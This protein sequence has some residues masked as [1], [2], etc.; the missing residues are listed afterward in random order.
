MK[1]NNLAT[2]LTQWS[3][4]MSQRRRRKLRPERRIR[5]HKHEKFRN[6]APSNSYRANFTLK[7]GYKTAGYKNNSHTR[8]IFPRTESCSSLNLSHIT[9]WEW[10]PL[11]F[12][13]QSGLLLALRYTQPLQ[14]I[15]SH[16][17]TAIFLLNKKGVLYP[18]S[19]VLWTDV[20]IK[21]NTNKGISCQT[22]EIK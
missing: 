20:E 7:T 11:L 16:L 8:Q 17:V 1:N 5:H 13:L 22:I 2:H 10:I 6:L 18:V 12:F 9:G 4:S 15:H 3:N 14:H 21:F 19:S